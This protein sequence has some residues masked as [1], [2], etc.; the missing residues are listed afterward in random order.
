MI[1]EH[2][3]IKVLDHG[4]VRLVDYMGDDASIVR[5]ARVS[6]NAAWRTGDNEKSDENLIRYLLRCHHST[7][8]EAGEIQLEVSAPLHVIRQWMRHRTWS[9]NELSARYKK[10]FEEFYIP[11]AD[12]IGTQSKSSKQA[13]DLSDA[14][15]VGLAKRE[16]QRSQIRLNASSCFDTYHQLLADGVP[17][18]LA[19]INLPLN[20]Y[21]HM[22][23]KVNLLN[24]FK[25]LQLRSHEHAQYEI[26]VYADAIYEIIKPLFPIACK[27][28]ED[29]MQGARSFSRMECEIVQRVKKLSP[30]TDA[31]YLNDEEYLKLSKRE[32]AEF[33][34]F[35]GIKTKGYK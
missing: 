12:K 22:F 8:F 14:T 35:L 5:A 4:Y 2:Q 23:A 30:D 7:P 18:E 28:F 17:R 3:P 13:R 31:L 33:C 34:E 11:D 19:R 27:A 9:Y 20:T 25:F 1:K 16:G 15:N 32:Q 29:Y 21:S 24:L 6:Y 10:I 26:R